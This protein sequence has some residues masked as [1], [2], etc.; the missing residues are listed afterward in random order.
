VFEDSYRGETVTVSLLELVI[1]GKSYIKSEPI[2]TYYVTRALS[3]I[4]YVF[5]PEQVK[6]KVNETLADYPLGILP[7]MYIR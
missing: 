1:V 5:G 3:K 7:I 4:G 6:V 2:W